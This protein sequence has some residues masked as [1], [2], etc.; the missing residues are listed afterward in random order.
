MVADL[1]SGMNDHKKGL[2]RLL[3][4]IL[5]DQIGRL[6]IAHK[7]RLLRFGA[8]LVFAICEAKK[9]EVVILKI[10]PSKKTWRKTFWR[11]SRFS[12]PA[13]MEA[14]RIKTRNGSTGLNVPWRKRVHDPRPQNRPRSQ[15]QAAQLFYAGIGYGAVCLQLGFGGMAAPISSGRKAF[16]SLPAP[17][18]E[19]AETG[20]IPVVCS[21]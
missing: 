12:A 16:G 21:T 15:R 9:V 6:V 11:L 8:E 13:S 4:G 1:G 5:D 2:K 3:T 17:S 20:A 14:G 19:C 7:D 10:R 18:I